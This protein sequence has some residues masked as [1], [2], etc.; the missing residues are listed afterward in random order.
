MQEDGIFNFSGT[1]LLSHGLLLHNHFAAALGA[2][3][4]LGFD[5]NDM[6][7]ASLD[8]PG[9]PRL[10]DRVFDSAMRAFNELAARPIQ[11]AC[12]RPDCSH[13]Y[14]SEVLATETAAREGGTPLARERTEGD[15]DQLE[16]YASGPD[17][18]I[19]FDE[20]FFP[21]AS[22]MRN[23]R[24]SGLHSITETGP[25]APAACGGF[26]P[27]SVGGLWPT[28]APG[29]LIDCEWKFCNG[30]SDSRRQCARPPCGGA[31]LGKHR[32]DA[33]MYPSLQTSSWRCGRASQRTCR[34]S[35]TW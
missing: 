18:V 31:T 20:T 22:A 23:A 1:N 21:D 17:K 16:T 12:K 30:L 7:A 2:P 8:G 3:H 35:S 15:A 34:H 6:A 10:D 4:T 33:A 5:A 27:L 14:T 32:R 26:T 9:T 19:T 24:E 28:D 13:L 11:H 25:G 29:E